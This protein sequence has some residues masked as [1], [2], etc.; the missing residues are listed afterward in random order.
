[1]F[2]PLRPLHLPSVTAAYHAGARVSASCLDLPEEVDS[3]TVRLDSG[4]VIA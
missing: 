2:D 4:N 3:G 1:M